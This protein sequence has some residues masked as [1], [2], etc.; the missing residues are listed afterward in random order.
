MAASEP[1]SQ[2]P[3]R[4]A[5]GSGLPRV[6]AGYDRR[7][8]T[9]D[10]QRD[11]DRIATFSDAV[12]AIAMTL[13]ALDLA[14]P[15]HAHGLGDALR[16]LHSAFVSFVISF[17][18]IG[19]Y[20]MAH[21]GLFAVIVRHD[22]KLLWI[23]LLLLMSIVATPFTT[24]VLADYGDRPGGVAVYAGSIATT[25]LL[26]ALLTWYAL[27]RGRLAAAGFD[28][29]AGRYMVLR[30]L[31]VPLV[32]LATLPLAWVSAG[33]AELSWLAIAPIQWLLQ[34][35]FEA[36]ARGRQAQLPNDR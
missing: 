12:F 5:G 26:M 31:A 10:A 22:R 21:H 11:V 14:L 18:V 13:L 1:Q 7:H 29:L 25:G 4:G 16:S 9:V 2:G 24:S 15:A 20:W 34:R 6:V 8:P 3:R 28:P 32:F 17:L 33:A 35:R 30:G 23:N 19:V 27:G 36:L